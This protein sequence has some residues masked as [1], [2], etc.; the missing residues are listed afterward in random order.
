MRSMDAKSTHDWAK[1]LQKVSSRVSSVSSTKQ[2]YSSTNERKAVLN[3]DIYHSIMEIGNL[4]EI[5]A[6]VMSVKK[7]HGSIGQLTIY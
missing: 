6:N 4:P 1:S 3:Q 2:K 7:K 5:S